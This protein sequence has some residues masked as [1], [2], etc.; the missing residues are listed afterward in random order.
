MQYARG[1]HD[2]ALLGY[3]KASELGFE[4]AQVN[5]AWMLSQNQGIPAGQ[6]AIGYVQPGNPPP[7]GPPSVALLWYHNPKSVY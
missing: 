6:S 3:L 7:P 1:R 4:A 5:V 2:L